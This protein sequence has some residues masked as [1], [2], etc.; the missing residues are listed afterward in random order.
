MRGPVTSWPD[1]PIIAALV[2]H[3]DGTLDLSGALITDN[4]DG[5]L[6]IGA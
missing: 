6:T 3:G 2:D 4:L 5:T 1:P